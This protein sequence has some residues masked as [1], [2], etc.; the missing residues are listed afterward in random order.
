MHIDTPKDWRSC[1]KLEF[2]Y[3]LGALNWKKD[4]FG[5]Y[6]IVGTHPARRFAIE[7]RDKDEIWVDPIYMPDGD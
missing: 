1:S 6:V 4:D 2:R 5:F 7:H 3:I